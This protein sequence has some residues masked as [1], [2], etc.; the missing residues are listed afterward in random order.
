MS[1]IKNKRAQDYE[2]LLHQYIIYWIGQILNKK[3]QWGKIQ[4]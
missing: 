3:I 2:V 1:T 4:R